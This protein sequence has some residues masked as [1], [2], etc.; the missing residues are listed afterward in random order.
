MTMI[1]KRYLKHN[2]SHGSP[3][4]LK[5]AIRSPAKYANKI[6][7]ALAV[8]GELAQHS[9]GLLRISFGEQMT[10]GSTT[11]RHEIGSEF[12]SSILLTLE[13]AYGFAKTI[14]EAAK[15]HGMN[16]KF[17]ADTLIDD[18]PDVEHTTKQ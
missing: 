2:W 18:M 8:N 10:I 6:V 17:D 4:D 1:E 13:A 7:S 3:E 11:E 12:H 9:G 15:E 16:K 5:A 14:M